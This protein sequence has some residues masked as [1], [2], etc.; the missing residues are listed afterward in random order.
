MMNAAAHPQPRHVPLPQP[1]TMQ[2][3]PLRMNGQQLLQNNIRMSNPTMPP[4]P[5]G[6]SPPNIESK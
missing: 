1:P 6:R 5:L 2:Q 3:Q 4:F